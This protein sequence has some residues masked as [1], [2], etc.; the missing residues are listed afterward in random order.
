MY[1]FL[2][3]L[4][5]GFAFNWASAFTHFYSKR[6]GERRGK[7]A[8]FILRNILG[9]PVWVY[10]LALAA[11]A[12]ASPLFIPRRATEILG[13]LLLFIGTIPMVWGLLLLGLRSFRPTEKDTL[14]SNGLFKYIRHPI[15]SGLLLAFIALILLRPTIPAILACLLGWGFVFILARLEELDLVHRLPAY[16]EYMQQVPRFFPRLRK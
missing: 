4:L 2:F 15:Y 7:L 13:W 12:S 6:W 8:C 16:R 5:A 9:I 10:G 14:V 11:R 1:F 3:P